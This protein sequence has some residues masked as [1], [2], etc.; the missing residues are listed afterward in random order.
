MGIYRWYYTVYL[1]RNRFKKNLTTHKNIMNCISQI[2]SSASIYHHLDYNY[3]QY[4]KYQIVQVIRLVSIVQISIIRNWHHLKDWLSG[5][6]FISHYYWYE[7]NWIRN[8][9][10]PRRK[11]A[12]TLLFFLLQ[13]FF[14]WMQISIWFIITVQS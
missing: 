6:I 11:F 14:F 9:E 4:Y 12:Q 5:S 3:V 8:S 1:E 10:K 13:V 2:A 7:I